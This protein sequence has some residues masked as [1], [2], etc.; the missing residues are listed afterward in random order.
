M[1]QVLDFYG[2]F[3][4]TTGDTDVY[5]YTADEFATLISG[6]TGDGISRQALNEFNATNNGLVITINSGICF[7][8]GRFG[9][10]DSAKTI[11][12]S[13]TAAGK[14]RYDIIYIKLDK[15]ARN[16][17][18]DVVRGAEALNP[19]EPTLTD[20]DTVKYMKIWKVLVQSG[21]TTT[22]YDMRPLTYSSTSIQEQMQE[23]DE[24]IKDNLNDMNGTLAISKGGTGATTAAGALSAL[25]AAAANHSHNN[26]VNGNRQLVVT[27]ATDAPSVANAVKVS[28]SES[29]S[30]AEYMVYHSGNIIVSSTEPANPVAGM[31]WLQTT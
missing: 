19:I 31:I 4:Y 26:L 5:E 25:G 12:L 6:L 18:L 28:T 10:N 14:K 8:D 20:T 24:R 27:N 22:L 7:I 2:M 30:A 1:A 29:G 23:L 13:A 11:T 17:V 15:T 9:K 3:D 21:S 16:I